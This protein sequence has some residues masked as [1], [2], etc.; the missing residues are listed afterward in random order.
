MTSGPLT[1][2]AATVS[3]DVSTAV[4]SRVGFEAVAQ[5][6]LVQTGER[7]PLQGFDTGST[8]RVKIRADK[9]HDAWICDFPTVSGVGL[10]MA[11]SAADESMV[12]HLLRR[13]SWRF[14]PSDERSAGVT[15]P[16]GSFAVLDASPSCLFEV[17]PGT[18]ADVLILPASVVRP[19]LRG[20]RPVVGSAGS[21]EARLLMAHTRTVREALGELGPAGVRAARDALVE[22][23]NATLAG[24]YDD[25]EPRLVPA[26]AR[27]AMELADEHLT[28]LDLTPSVLARQ[29]NV[30]V[31]TLHRAFAA[32]GEP[33][34][35][36][37]RRRRLEQ[38]RAELGAALHQPS[39]SEV[40]ARYQF[41]DGSHF[42]RAF[43]AEY[44]QTP[45]EFARSQRATPSP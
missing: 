23:A 30:S 9:L 43:K 40:A 28:D 35:G 36:Y 12:L 14:A 16:S 8:I 24:R 21:A 10:T 4:T 17:T 3:V 22:L 19:R 37:V 13:G 41:A 39:V 15:A 44:G 33:V 34:A 2:R 31:R 29:L 26:L 1:G 5:E 45:A 27:A 20:G 7:W 18:A 38:A 11:G 42:A 25:V 32:V 6:W